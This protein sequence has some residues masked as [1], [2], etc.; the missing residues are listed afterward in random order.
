MMIFMALNDDVGKISK[1]LT[2]KQKDFDYVM[3]TSRDIIR[4]SG[5]A[6]T[7]LHNDDKKAAT[8]TLK[9]IMASV[10][11]L[12][13]IDARF[14]YYTLQAY[15]EYVEAA[16]FF[17]IKAQRAIP[18]AAKLGVEAESYLLGLMDVVGELKREILESLRADNLE[19]AEFYFDNM[20]KIYDGT[21][22]LRFAEA[23]LTGFRRKQDTARIQIENA[24]SEILSFRNSKR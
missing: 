24:G 4:E 5:Q 23:V 6:I 2:E 18:S 19:S 15:Q 20:K 22:R 9:K 16:T 7:M 14:K 10:K 11:K 3:D 8:K 13:K 1:Y 12:K 21:R 17:E